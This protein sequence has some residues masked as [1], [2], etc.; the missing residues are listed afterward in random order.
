MNVSF[1]NRFPPLP[2]PLI[3]KRRSEWHRGAGAVDPDRAFPTDA[4][5]LGAESDLSAIG[6]FGRPPADGTRGKAVEHDRARKSGL[7]QRRGG[8]VG[9]EVIIAVQSE[10]GRER[11]RR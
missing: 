7:R 8:I 6:E 1:S 4:A 3:K 11:D 2:N 10:I 5:D 9:V